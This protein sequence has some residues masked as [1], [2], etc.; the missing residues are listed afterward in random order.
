MSE[1]VALQHA[2]LIDG[3]G[4]SPVPD[5]TVLVADGLISAAGPT[6]SVPVPAQAQ[7][8]DYSGSYLIPGLMDANVHLVSARTLRVRVS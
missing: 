4:R 7:V 3:T 1:I 2:T 6:A 5:A 8:R